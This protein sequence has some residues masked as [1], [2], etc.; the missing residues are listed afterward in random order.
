MTEKGEET[1]REG[2]EK[3]TGREGE[4]NREGKRD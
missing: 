2:V 4:T 3:P 1:N